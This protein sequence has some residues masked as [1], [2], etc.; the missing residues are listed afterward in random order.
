MT[1]K[2]LDKKAHMGVCVSPPTFRH[3]LLLWR[4]AQGLKVPDQHGK[5][6]RNSCVCGWAK[7]EQSLQELAGL[8]GDW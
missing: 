1:P 4:A 7:L 3:L 2:D 8:A 5:L 6:C